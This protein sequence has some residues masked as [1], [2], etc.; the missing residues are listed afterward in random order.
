MSPSTYTY[1]WTQTRLETVQ[2]QFR[3]LLAYG[4]FSDAEIDPVIEGITEKVI[5]AIGMYG[6]DSS[7][8]RV[9]ETELRV[10]WSL[11][12]ELTLKTPTL[13]GGMSG[14][15]GRQAPEIK[16]AGRRFAGTAH[17]LGLTANYWIRLA[18]RVKNDPA[19]L[20]YWRGRLKLRGKPPEW[21][22]DPEVRDENLYDLNEG[23]IYMRYA[24]D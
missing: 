6:Y 15:D 9:I 18:R 11:N 13:S 16:V 17:D 12:A 14:W 3:Y 8:L 19:D 5:D 7:G 2:D 24:G 23:T 1:T 20:S 10:D 21:K 4:G 22:R